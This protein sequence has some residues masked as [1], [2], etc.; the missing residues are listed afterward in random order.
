MVKNPPSNADNSGSI[1]VRE[2]RSYMLGQ[3]S[4]CAAIMEL[5]HSDYMPQLKPRATMKELVF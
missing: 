3:L 4:L 2:L 5:V 1:S